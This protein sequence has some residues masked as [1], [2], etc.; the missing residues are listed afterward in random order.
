MA[1]LVNTSDGWQEQLAQLNM[2][3]ACLASANEL[4]RTG[5]GVGDSRR[6]E[7]GLRIMVMTLW[8]SIQV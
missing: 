1:V 2:I 5:V 3:H 4:E 7:A 8:A 6:S